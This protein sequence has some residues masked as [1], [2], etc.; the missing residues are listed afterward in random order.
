MATRKAERKERKPTEAEV[1]EALREYWKFRGRF[2]SAVES[3]Y[4]VRLQRYCGLSYKEAAVAASFN[5]M[6][7][8]KN[9]AARIGC[10]D[11]GLA[12]IRDRGRKKIRSSGYE[13]DP[14]LYQWIASNTN[15][16]TYDPSE[17]PVF[18]DISGFYSKYSREKTAYEDVY[19]PPQEME[20]PET[21]RPIEK[22]TVMSYAIA[23]VQGR[24]SIEYPQA[25]GLLCRLR[26]EREL[27][28][29]GFGDDV[30]RHRRKG[31]RIDTGDFDFS[32]D[33]KPWIALCADVA[34]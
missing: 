16:I 11:R 17:D 4:K 24:F 23:I 29:A 18:G 5:F 2:Y 1:D 32:G 28:G 3:V 20:Y 25:V 13:T 26:Y 15:V 19:V 31:R 10:T 21:L 8:G 12:T 14:A 34:A 30:D 9:L 22:E 6:H 27:R 33:L 7:R